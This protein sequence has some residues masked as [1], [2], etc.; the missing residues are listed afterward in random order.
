MRAPGARWRRVW[1]RVRQVWVALGVA[2][3][4]VFTAWSLV[5]YRATGAARAALA[6]DAAVEVRRE[7]G[8][9]H[10][11]PRAPLGVER[12]DRDQPR[13]GLLFFPG[14]LVDP[15]AYA[16]LLR[17]AAGRGHPAVLMALPRRG[18]FGGAGEPAVSASARAVLQGAGGG[19][20]RW[21]VGGHS[22]G[23]VLAV[24]LAARRTPG[25]AGLLLV[26]TSHPR[27]VD[28]AALGVPV[29]KVVG[30]RDGLASPADVMENR[31]R[32]PAA[33]RWVWVS[34]GN[35]S[36]FGWY[37]F[38]PG[39]RRAT[40]PAGAQHAALVDATLALLAAVAAA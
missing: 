20:R 39:D 34:G 25:L 17:A 13:V 16:P 3:T 21:V 28:L 23:A 37:G 6:S 33:T 1:R 18:A 24:A 38:Q 30:T 15:V 7:A 14:A 32:L 35:H 9:W 8:G 10:F 12:T 27:D 36:Q 4:V 40:L 5:A 26:G 19:P 22:R 11:R 2:A 31:A 29:T